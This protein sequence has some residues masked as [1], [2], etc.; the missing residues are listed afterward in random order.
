MLKSSTAVPHLHKIIN[1]QAAGDNWR[2]IR[3]RAKAARIL[4][5]LKSSAYGHGLL[6]MAHALGDDADGI[7][8][9]CPKDAIALRNDG[10]RKP[11]MLLEGVF[12]RAELPLL[13]D[14][15]LSPVVHT[16]W[17]LQALSELPA[18][19]RLTVF[20]KINTDMN[21]LGFQLQDATAA[22]EQLRHTASVHDIVLMTHFANADKPNS[23]NAAL[24]SL[25][26]LRS[27]QRLPV[28]LGNSAATLLADDIGDDWARV[29]IALYGASPAPA[30][31]SPNALGLAPVMSLQTKLI[32]VSKVRR[33]ETIGYGG[34][35]TADTD[36]LIGVADVGYGNGYP[37]RKGLFA[38]INNTTVPAVGRVSMQMT[39]FDLSSCPAAAVGDDFILWGKTPTVDAVATAAETISYDLLTAVTSVPAVI[40]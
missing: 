22:V 23:I 7:G 17:Q 30:R 27:S 3:K 40:Q 4:A 11:I 36:M 9:V 14:W 32:S 10:Y 33:G 19:A 13:A 26:P 12:E 8:V 21:R 5:I 24:A 34:D 38:C 16:P 20:L 6:A 2:A 1:T 18:S 37:R 15:Q 28:S 31:Y 35:Y 29:G 25:A 39:A